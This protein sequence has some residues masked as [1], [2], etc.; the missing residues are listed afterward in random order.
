METSKNKTF[1]GQIEQDLTGDCWLLAGLNSIIAKPKMLKELEKLVKTDPKTGD[2]LITMKGINKTYRVTRNDLKE[3]TTIAKGSEKVNAVE[4]AMDKYIRDEAYKDK[5]RGHSIDD[6]FGYVSDV[7]IDAN[8]SSFLWRTLFGDN[9]NL[10]DI[11]IDPSTEDFNNPD[12]VY[13]MSLRGNKG[14]D[15]YGLAK[16]EKNE[17]YTIIARHAYS[18]IGSDE[19]NIYLLN[20][21]DSADKIT[22]TRE[23]FKKLNAHIEKYEIPTK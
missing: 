16:S 18:I 5:E 1:N 9:Y 12:R 6:E 7:T 23:N 21:W 4:I 15:V 8:Y 3:Y 22:I 2:Y 20:P 10:Y 19:N 11:K 17:I 14:D 13:E